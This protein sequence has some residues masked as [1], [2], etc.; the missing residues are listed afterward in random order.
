[1]RKRSLR[2]LRRPVIV[3]GFAVAIVTGSAVAPAAA[4]SAL[5]YAETVERL[6]TIARAGDLDRQIAEAAEHITGE[7]GR[8]SFDQ[9]AAARDVPYEI[10]LLTEDVVSAN[11]FMMSQIARGVRLTDI[12]LS[13]FTLV[14]AL[15]ED[16]EIAAAQAARPKTDELSLAALN[17][18]GEKV[19]PL[20]ATNPKRVVAVNMKTKEQAEKYFRDTGYHPTIHYACG[21]VYKCSHDWTRGRAYNS[22]YGHCASPRFRDHGVRDKHERATA[23]YGEPN[24]EVHSYIWPYPTWPAYVSWWHNTR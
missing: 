5:T 13:Q 19:N 8:H 22:K 18:C 15:L 14:T 23:Q 7:Q 1:M 21:A 11:N 9:Q 10:V 17:A 3:L 24:P 16:P 6:T 2:V 12:D 4:T 20:P